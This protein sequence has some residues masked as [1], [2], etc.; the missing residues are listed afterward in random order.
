MIIK[1]VVG[2]LSLC[3]ICSS[4]MF[5]KPMEVQAAWKRERGGWTFSEG[6]S[7]ALGWRKID[8]KW[9]YF[10]TSASAKGIMQT[11]WNKIGGNWYY[12]NADG[13]M[14]T[15]WIQ[16]GS[17]W[18]YL[19]S[20]GAMAHD[21][22]V[23]GYYVNSS[24]QWVKKTAGS[25]STSGGSSSNK[26]SLDVSASAARALITKNDS[27]FINNKTS[28][29]RYLEI[30][31]AGAYSVYSLVNGKWDIENEPCYEFQVI[32]KT[33]SGNEFDYCNYIVGKES[34]KVYAI[35]NQAGLSAYQISNN[36]IVKTYKWKQGKSVGWR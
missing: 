20:N 10:S 8:N 26:S 19:N 5:A 36:K 25:S 11:G 16:N 15:G 13:V 33:D 23:G 12:M 30:D 27:K 7:N 17:Y 22:T 2:I 14:Q 21:T 31:Y 32:D 24:G 6:N 18:Y 34:G 35:P 3:C 28:D 4:V 9:Y 29:G 1:K